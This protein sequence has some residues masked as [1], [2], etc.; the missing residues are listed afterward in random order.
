[1][2]VRKSSVS[3]LPN[4]PRFAARRPPRQRYTA[5]RSPRAAAPSPAS[6]RCHLGGLPAAP[7]LIG[8][9]RRGPTRQ[10]R[11]Q[12]TCP[13]GSSSLSWEPGSAW[14]GRASGERDSSFPYRR[15]AR[16]RGGRSLR[17]RGHLRRVDG[18]AGACVRRAGGRRVG[19]AVGP[20][21]G[22]EK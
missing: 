18:G 13:A 17:A 4:R 3:R 7:G 10:R 9:A 22:G 6:R 8:G 12:G 19:S 15:G 14:G 11:A 1:M 20:S 2:K 16:P 5:R 21:G